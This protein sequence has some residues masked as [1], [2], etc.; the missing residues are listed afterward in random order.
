MAFVDSTEWVA[1]VADGSHFRQFAPSKKAHH[2]SLS[3]N[4][5]NKGIIIRDTIISVVLF[6]IQSDRR[7]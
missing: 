5:K 1:R 7:M 4:N 2:A 6:D 3:E